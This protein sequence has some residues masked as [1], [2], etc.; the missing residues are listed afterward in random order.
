MKEVYLY[1]EVA[2]RFR[3]PQDRNI[4]FDI[5]MMSFEY[6]PEWVPE[7]EMYKALHAENK[8]WITEDTRVKKQ[9]EN[10]GL[11]PEQAKAKES[12]AKAKND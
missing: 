6:A 2:A 8:A 12:K 1:S 7:S 10:D 9:L 4:K 3:H 5:G 11:K